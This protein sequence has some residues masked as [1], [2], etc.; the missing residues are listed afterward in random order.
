[1]ESVSHRPDRSRRDA[2][3]EGDVRPPVPARP[4]SGRGTGGYKAVEARRAEQARAG[5]E[6]PPPPPERAAMRGDGWRDRKE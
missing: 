4:P 1:M 5:G 6:V 2:D 3:E